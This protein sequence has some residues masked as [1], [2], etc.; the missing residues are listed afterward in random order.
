MSSIA[1]SAKLTLSHDDDS[2]GLF[3][4]LEDLTNRTKS[5]WSGSSHTNAV[6]A[7]MPPTVRD[8]ST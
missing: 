8:K 7:A 3:R 5:A 6:P 2:S 4:E 1:S